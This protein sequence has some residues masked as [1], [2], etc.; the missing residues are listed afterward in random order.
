MSG[1]HRADTV[2]S[3]SN[4]AEIEGFAA[5]EDDM[6]T[7]TACKKFEVTYPTLELR[8][9]PGLGHQNRE[10]DVLYPSA[11]IMVPVLTS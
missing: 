8:D 5:I 3:L 11:S 2:E 4:V 7:F 1:N 10:L 9:T 6:L